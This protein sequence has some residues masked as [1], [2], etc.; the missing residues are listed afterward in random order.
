MLEIL[1]R[2]TGDCAVL[3][4][5]NEDISPLLRGLNGRPFSSMNFQFESP[6]GAGRLPEPPPNTTYYAE[7]LRLPCLT[8]IFWG[9]ISSLIGRTL[10]AVERQKTVVIRREFFLLHDTTGAPAGELFGPLRDRPNVAV[11]SEQADGAAQVTVRCLYCDAGWPRPLR[12]AHWT[13]EEGL[14]LVRPL[15]FDQFANFHGHRLT[16]SVLRFVPFVDYEETADG[17]LI[18]QP[19]IDFNALEVMSA[20]WNFTYAIKKPTDLSWG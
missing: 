5:S 18:P 8:H 6:L 16:C 13:A 1:A 10:R 15:F 19:S 7:V 17:Q 11:V 12:A 9:N 3:T 2:H 4:F 20:K 14:Q